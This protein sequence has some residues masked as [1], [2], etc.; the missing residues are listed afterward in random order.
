MLSFGTLSKAYGLPGLRVGWRVVP[1]GLVSELVRIRDYL[2]LSLSP[3]V[4]R[5]AACRRGARRRPDH[6][7]G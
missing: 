3:L 5:V 1:Q 7:L 6:S 4:E 2:T